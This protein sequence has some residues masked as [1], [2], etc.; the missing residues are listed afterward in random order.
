MAQN[1]IF[2]FK[3]KDYNVI[4]FSFAINRAID[5]RGRPATIVRANSVEVTL[6]ASNSNDFASWAIGHYETAE[7]KF[8]FYNRDEASTMRSLE[9][10]DAH[11]YSYLEKYNNNNNSPYL[12]ELKITCNKI[13]LEPGGI[14]HLN[15]WDNRA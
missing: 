11:C 13:T 12:I 1:A 5:E 7:G 8:I 9:F 4:D 14:N 10:K 6:E 3:S 2:K 15:D